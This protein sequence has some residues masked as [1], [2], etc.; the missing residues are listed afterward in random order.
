MTNHLL[1]TAILKEW[2]MKRACSSNLTLFMMA[3][4]LES[5]GDQHIGGSSDCLKSW[6]I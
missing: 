4:Y 3:L 6:L 2:A 5:R 1:L